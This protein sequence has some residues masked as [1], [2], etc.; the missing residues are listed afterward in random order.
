MLLTT[1]KRKGDIV[2]TS[3]DSIIHNIEVK[4]GVQAIESNAKTVFY[5]QDDERK[6]IG[7]MTVQKG[8]KRWIIL[9]KEQFKALAEEVKDIYDVVFG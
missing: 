8:V 6:H 7:I 9:T 2:A 1:T 3:S 4:Y 5:L